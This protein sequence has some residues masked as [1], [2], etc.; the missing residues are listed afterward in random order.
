MEN[1]IVNKQEN[2]WKTYYAI[3]SLYDD[4]YEFFKHHAIIGKYFPS[5]DDDFIAQLIFE[6][7]KENTNVPGWHLFVTDYS[8]KMSYQFH[9]SKMRIRKHGI[10]KRWTKWIDLK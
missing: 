7:N 5:K 3:P 2:G 10:F 4:F 6:F 1:Q 8:K 9:G